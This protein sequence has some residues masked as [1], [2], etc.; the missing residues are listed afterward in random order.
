MESYP[1]FHNEVGVSIVCIGSREFK[2]IAYCRPG[3]ET[4]GITDVSAKIRSGS[5]NKLNIARAT[6]KALSML[7]ARRTPTEK[8]VKAEVETTTAK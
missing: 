3:N 1:K 6:I 2:C 7:H 4:A 5:K 8:T